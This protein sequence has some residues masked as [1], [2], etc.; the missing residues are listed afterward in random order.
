MYLLEQLAGQTLPPH[1]VILV[2]S[3]STDR[4]SRL[5][6]EWVTSHQSG[7]RF[8]NLNMSTCTPGGSKSAGIKHSTTSLV[9]FMDCGLSFPNDWLQ[10][11]LTLLDQFR[12]DWV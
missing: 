4:S 9:A 8:R 11:Q 5:I 10:R 7:V 2:N 12:A 3:G 1:E 6:D